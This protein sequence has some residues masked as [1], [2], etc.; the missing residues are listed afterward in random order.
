MQ[1][2][3]GN[4]NSAMSAISSL[5]SR[6]RG[7]GDNFFEGRSGNFGGYN[8]DGSIRYMNPNSGPTDRH[9]PEIMEQQPPKGEPSKSG[10][11]GSPVRWSGSDGENLSGNGAKTPFLGSQTGGQNDPLS[12]IRSLFGPQRPS[13]G[14]NIPGQGQW[15]TPYSVPPSRLGPIVPPVPPWY[16]QPPPWWNQPQF[17]NMPWYNN[18]G[19]PSGGPGSPGISGYSDPDQGGMDGNPGVAGPAGSV[20]TPGPAGPTSDAGDAW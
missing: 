3:G 20:G 10:R 6:G 11:L 12:Y 13:Y 1:G 18:G 19:G 9:V 17:Q 5:L 4:T 8:P 16:S 2:F 7:G 14:G 15:P